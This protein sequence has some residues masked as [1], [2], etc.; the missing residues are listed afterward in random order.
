MLKKIVIMGFL[1]ALSS[2]FACEC[3]SDKL[4]L[5]IKG[6]ASIISSISLFSKN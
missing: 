6:S 3:Q 1:G 2:V 4:G 5:S